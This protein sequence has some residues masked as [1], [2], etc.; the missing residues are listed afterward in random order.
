MPEADKKTCK[1]VK[2]AGQRGARIAPKGCKVRTDI[3]A[4]GTSTRRNKAGETKIKRTVGDNA[5][6]MTVAGANQ[7]SVINGWVDRSTVSKRTY[8]ATHKML[9]DTGAEVTLMSRA[10]CEKLGIKWKRKT[11]VS[12][13]IIQGVGGSETLKIL[14]DVEFYLQID[15]RS[16]QWT[17]VTAD[18]NVKVED[19]ST[20]NL[21]GIDTIR[22][23]KRLNVKFRY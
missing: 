15:S 19:S 12:S 20:S 10:L 14:H 17:K 7:Q 23:I 9:Y 5:F 13:Q 22:Q 1:V 21:L 11:N 3:S 18:I 6:F 8:K 2:R 16:N 4:D